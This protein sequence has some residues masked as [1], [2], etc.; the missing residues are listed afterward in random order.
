M[1]A[2]HFPP[3]GGAGVHRSVGTARHLPEYGYEAVVITGPGIRADRWSPH[4]PGLLEG[5]PEG[6]EVHRL[7]GSDPGEASGMR[8]RADRWLQRRPQ[9]VS[10]WLDGAIRAGLEHGRGADLVYASC[11]PYETAVAGAELARALGVPWVADLEDP[12]ALDEMRV[13]PTAV[14]RRRDLAAMRAALRT[15]SAIVM[16]A[17]EAAARVRRSL[18][19][20]AGRPVAAIPIGFE[21]TEFETPSAGR[22]D[23]VFRIVH[24]GSMHTELGTQHRR[25]AR[26]RRLLGGGSLDVD[27]L[28]RSHVFLLQAI[29][30]A[31]EADPAR[32]IE[33]H[34]A[35]GLTAGDRAAA[36]P[37]D[38]VREHGQLGHAETV[39]LMKSADL[40]FLPM[41]EL[42]PGHRAG[43]IPYKTYEYLAA[44]RPILAAVPDGDVRDMLGPLPHVTL[45]RPS[46]VEAM[47][48]A[49]RGRLADPS[50]GPAGPPL[51]EEP[52]AG[53][54]RGRL[55]GRIAGVLDEVLGAQEAGAPRRSATRS[56]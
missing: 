12:W 11:I 28:T 54:H 46:D 24:T 32:R 42:P 55:V 40:L 51:D 16:C 9:S 53:L 19:G 18:P 29:E 8:A 20:N 56:R 5:I 1:L 45:C 4:D 27:I 21:A 3:I 2:R 25:S 10:W 15:A 17:P 41:H 23:G 37:Y 47:A 36:E 35:G 22:A 31:L 14:H 50:P 26:A 30:R 49:I 7:P 43:L 52:L 44:R 38:F 34:L 48:A 33:L 13:Q 6:L 39:A